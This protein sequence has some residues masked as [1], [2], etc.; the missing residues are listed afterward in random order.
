MTNEEQARPLEFAS[1]DELIEELMLREP[2]GCI[3][4][5]S[6]RPTWWGGIVAMGLVALLKRRID[7]SMYE[8]TLMCEME[9]EESD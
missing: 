6:G 5:D 9:D 3:V 7:D 2:A 8:C 4:L 1:T